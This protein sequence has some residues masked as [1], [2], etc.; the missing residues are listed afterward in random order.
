[1]K[2]ARRLSQYIRYCTLVMRSIIPTTLASVLAT[3]LPLI[4]EAQALAQSVTP[5]PEAWRP[6][7]YADLQ[8]PSAATATYVDIWKDAIESNNQAYRERGDHR[9]VDSNAPVTEAHFTI[10]SPTRSVVLTILNT[11]IGC[12]M[13]ASMPQARATVK[14][15]PLRIAVYDGLRVRTMDGGRAC[16]LEL[17]GVVQDAAASAAYA[18]YDVSSRTVKIGMIVDHKAVD[19]CSLEVP[20][21]PRSTD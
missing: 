6:M 14:F 7:S 21:A 2:V 16:F 15:C 20:L 17:V 12:T 13:K 18:A 5:D 9:F 4:M 11:A 19:G 1:M 8:R 10:W 3:G